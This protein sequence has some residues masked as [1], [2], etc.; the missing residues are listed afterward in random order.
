MMVLLP[1][2]KAGFAC[3]VQ[4]SSP[5]LYSCPRVPTGRPTTL[6]SWLVAAFSAIVIAEW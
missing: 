3:D 1:E 5:L 4:L 6:R 2:G